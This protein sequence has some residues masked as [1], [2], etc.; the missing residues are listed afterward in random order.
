[1]CNKVE[2]HNSF[3][4]FNRNSRPALNNDI[5]GNKPNKQEFLYV[6]FKF[7]GAVYAIQTFR[8]DYNR[9]MGH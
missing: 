1:M 7:H 5:H 2:L 8:P 6:L 9:T 4:C 3:F